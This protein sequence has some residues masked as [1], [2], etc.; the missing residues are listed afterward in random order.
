ME[1]ERNVS[2]SNGMEFGIRDSGMGV[3]RGAES[4]G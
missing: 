3:G 2:V 1:M 4:D